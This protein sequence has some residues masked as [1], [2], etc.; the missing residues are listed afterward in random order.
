MRHRHRTE[1]RTELWGYFFNSDKN[2]STFSQRKHAIPVNVVANL[3]RKVGIPVLSTPVRQRGLVLL[4]VFFLF[5]FF[6]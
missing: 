1:H 5:F 3:S 2:D 4:N 6:S